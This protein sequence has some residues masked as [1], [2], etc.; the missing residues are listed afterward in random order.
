MTKLEFLA[1]VA[2]ADKTQG[3]YSDTMKEEWWGERSKRLWG[4]DDRFISVYEHLLDRGFKVFVCE[5][6]RKKKRS[7][8]RMTIC[9]FAHLWLPEVNL[10][11]RYSH[12]TLAEGNKSLKR[13]LTSASKYVYAGVINKDTED[14]IA[15][16][17]DLI[18]RV[19]EYRKTPTKKGVKDTI[20]KPKPKK[21]R[22]RIVSAQKA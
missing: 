1:S 13:F 5:I 15:Y 22:A 20:V 17:D 3:N 9:K 14:P 8:H 12:T 19:F 18:D 7:G 21:K 16:V 11:I 4:F 10:A 2:Q 6:L